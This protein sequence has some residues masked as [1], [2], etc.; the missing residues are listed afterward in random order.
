VN[1]CGYICCFLS[2]VWTIVSAGAPVALGAERLVRVATLQIPGASADHPF[3]DFDLSFVDAKRDLYLLSD[4]SNKSIDAFRASTGAFLFRVGGFFG[5]VPPG[6]SHV[7][8]T[9]VITVGEEIWA[10]DAPS[11]VKV[12]GLNTRRVIDAISTGGSARADTLSYDER[13]QM[14]LVTN[15]DDIPRFV[16]L[17]SAKP[18]HKVLGRIEFPHATGELEASAWW[19]A[20]GFFYL[21]VRELDG[22]PTKGAL[23]AID[24]VAKSV[25]STFA[26]PECRPTG[27]AIGEEE[28]GL[29]GCLG[30]EP[31]MNHAFPAQTL[32]MNLRTGVISA[33]INGV[34]GEDQVWFNPGDNRYYVA[35]QGNRTGPILAAISA[36]KSHSVLTV[37]TQPWA[38]SVA[39]DSTTNQV[40]VPFGPKPSDRDCRSGCVAVFAVMNDGKD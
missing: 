11:T 20:T 23:V 8:P 26:V 19:P 36:D 10:A 29:L 37:P 31:R 24:P 34:T 15:P 6:Y 17:V 13:D 22:D 32:I 21:L 38:H 9:G 39:A 18:G 28:E 7:G 30:P 33:R 25:V 35:A 5:H 4:I 3:K 40:F 1:R 2:V 14:V 12:I 16:T 27:V